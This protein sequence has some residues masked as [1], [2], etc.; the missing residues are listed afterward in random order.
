MASIMLIFMN[1]LETLFYEVVYY[2]AKK[3]KKKLCGGEHV[4]LMNRVVS[5]W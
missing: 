1:E 5:L 3:K 2:D 4:L